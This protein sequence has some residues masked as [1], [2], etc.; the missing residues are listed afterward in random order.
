[1]LE[2]DYDLDYKNPKDG[3]LKRIIIIYGG[4]RREGL[5]PSNVFSIGLEDG[6]V[7]TLKIRDAKDMV[8]AY[9]EAPNVYNDVNFFK[10]SAKKS[11][12]V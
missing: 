7:N 2:F 11:A 12:A 1:M 3:N 9:G 8:E 6:E 5:A 4:R 10:P